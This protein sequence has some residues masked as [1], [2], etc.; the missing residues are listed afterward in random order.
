MAQLTTANL[1]EAKIDWAS[2]EDLSASIAEVTRACIGTAD[3][4]WA[5]IKDLTTGTAI[6]ERGLS[7]KLYVADLAVTE[8]NMASLTVGELVVRGTDGCFY[9]VSVADDGSVVTTKKSVTSEDVADNSLP[10]GKLLEG[11]ITARELNVASIFADTALV[12]AITAANIDVSNLFAA[13][14]FIAQLNAVNI[15]GN[16][17]LQLMVEEASSNASAQINITADTIRQEVKDG[18]ASGDALAQTNARLGTLSEQSQ[19]HFTWAVSK[20]TELERDMTAGQRATDAQ[21]ALINT[22]MSFDK[23]GL[24]IGKAGNPFT[25][26]VVNDRLSF[27]MNNTE[28]AYLSDNK[29]YV[30]QAE[31][32]MRLQIGKFAYE[33]QIN[34]NLSVIFTG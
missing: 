34:G 4:D 19:S 6:I 31:I 27:F 20:A 30:T 16:E 33:P 9:A 17:S 1:H 10:G 14:A 32:L 7:G 18:F 2:I 12:G 22:Y 3:I 8:A 21:L 5:H 25:F 26:R 13:E 15:S 28:V 11:T 29:L 24:I 23:N